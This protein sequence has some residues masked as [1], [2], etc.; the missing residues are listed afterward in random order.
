MDGRYR[1]AIDNLTEKSRIANLY[2]ST[3]S[4]FESRKKAL[5]GLTQLWLGGYW[6]EPKIPAKFKEKIQKDPIRKN[7]QEQ[8]NR[9]KR[10]KKRLQS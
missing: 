6:S 3:K 8:L 9:N 4:A 7:Q 1:D 10:L 5:E 2:Y